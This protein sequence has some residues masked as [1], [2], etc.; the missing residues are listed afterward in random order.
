MTARRARA[1]AL[2]LATVLLG[3]ASPAFSCGPFFPQA[4]FT[5]TRHPD[6]PLENFLRGQLGIVLPTYSRSY[7]YLSYR[8]LAGKP[9]SPEQFAALE[10][11]WIRRRPSDVSGALQKAPKPPNWIKLWVEARKK[12]PGLDTSAPT[13]LGV[14]N[15]LGA[16][17]SERIGTTY[18]GYYNCLS[19]AFRTAVHTL[20][21]RVGRF[22]ADSAAVNSWVQAQDRVFANCSG[23]GNGLEKQQFLPLKASAED[24]PLIRADRAYQMG[25]AHFYAGN[26]ET[27]GK[28]FEEIAHDPD[29]PWSWLA[30]L[31]VARSLI[32]QATVYT[33]PGKP[34]LALLAKAETQ[35]QKVL[36]DNS[37]RRTHPS[38]RRLLGYVQLRLRPNQRI[39]QLREA[40]LEG[41]SPGTLRQDLTD[42][43]A[44]LGKWPAGGG[45]G[46]RMPLAELR[47][48]DEL[49]DWMLTFQRQ[50]SSARDH[51]MK[52]W[53]ET[54]SLPWLV[55]AISKAQAGG[56]KLAAL[57]EA[58]GTIPRNSSAF[59]TIAFHRARLLAAS[60][61]AAR[62]RIALEQML[63]K[64]MS[65]PRSSINL[66]L[67]L[68]MKL[69]RNLDE[70]LRGARRVPAR[71]GWNHF[72]RVIAEQPADR[73][74][75]QPRPQPRWLFDADAARIFTERMP[76]R[77]LLQ[78]SGSKSL[79]P[80]LRREVALATWVRCVLLD[81]EEVCREV[82]P[83]LEQLAPELKGDLQKYVS[84]PNSPARR[85]AAVF[86]ILRFPGLHLYVG[87]GP[88]RRTPLARIDNLRENWW[89]RLAPA[90]RGS[91]IYMGYRHYRM[92]TTFHMPLK[93]LYPSHELDY[94]A[95]LSLAQKAEAARE[96]EQLSALETAPSHLGRLVLEWAK[97][98]PDDPRVPQAL[99]LT[100]KATRYG[101][102]DQQTGHYS[103]A[104]FQFL[105]RKYPHSSWAKKTKY[106]Y[107]F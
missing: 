96:W 93:M 89:C 64:D 98:H 5:F 101:C 102:V 9:F 29:S 26:F 33:E 42:Y 88:A 56:P 104:A 63:A 65:L 1:C 79:P 85:F 84:S 49:A 100:V 91:R 103:K 22:G 34:D 50:T 90:Q 66:V 107:R 55:A 53:H 27:A 59:P 45:R 20:E 24:S 105:H 31:L 68:Q 94:P 62:A 38:A 81:R 47:A 35:L 37:L 77:L 17:R 43:L 40:L 19:D 70:L 73:R 46:N 71:V 32:R 44:L 76:L 10:G 80:N 36:A 30:P 25:A 16:Y 23:G 4:V 83:I 51:A 41:T 8:Y 12:I 7:L 97:N 54:G 28:V 99:H 82:V 18:I 58:A 69:A 57:L 67:A 48:E 60:G 86:T 78:A 87:A 74:G 3:L 92:D 39:C 75:R 95:F 14:H 15:P 6:L 21:E 52:K 11:V 72:G 13:P 106:W 61:E 2:L